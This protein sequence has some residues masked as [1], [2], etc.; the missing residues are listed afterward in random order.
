MNL[1]QLAAYE[2]MKIP[3]G[4]SEWFE[5][6]DELAAEYEKAMYKA[7]EAINNLEEEGK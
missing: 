3:S 4:E 5:K 7:V 6:H 2:I 1:G